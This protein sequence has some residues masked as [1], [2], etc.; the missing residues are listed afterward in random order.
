M[1]AVSSTHVTTIGSDV[2]IT[3]G[4]ASIIG[5]VLTPAAADAVIGVYDGASAGGNIK[6]HISAKANERSN[7]IMLPYPIKVTEKLVA[8]AS[9]A[10]AHATVI[11]GS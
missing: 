9:G 3:T 6:L 11:Y 10:G 7:S 8:I 1:T 5:L 2:D 4:K